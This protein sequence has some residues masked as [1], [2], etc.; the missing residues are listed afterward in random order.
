MASVWQ[1]LMFESLSAQIK[2]P[3]HGACFFGHFLL[4][5]RGYKLLNENGIAVLNLPPNWNN[6]ETYIQLNYKRPNGT[7]FFVEYYKPEEQPFVTVSIDGGGFNIP[8][9]Q[10][11]IL[12]GEATFEEMFPRH[13]ELAQLFV[14]NFQ[15]PPTPPHEQPAVPIPVDKLH[16]FRNRFGGI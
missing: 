16:T 8:L 4:I 14:S 13:R 9:N 15:L 3:V 10:Q 1:S 11:F 2:Q 7:S 6:D 5:E 12:V